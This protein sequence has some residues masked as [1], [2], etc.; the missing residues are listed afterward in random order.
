MRDDAQTADDGSPEPRPKVSSGGERDRQCVL[1]RTLAYT[2]ACLA[3]DPAAAEDLA[4]DVVLL[5]LKKLRADAGCFPDDAAL[6]AWAG[7][8]IRGRVLNWILSG[9]SRDAHNLAVAES[10][11]R[12]EGRRVDPAIRADGRDAL[13]RLE[14]AL[15]QMAERQRTAFLGTRDGG[16]SYRALASARRVSKETVRRQVGQ[17]F[18]DLRDALGDAL[19]FDDDPQWKVRG[20]GRRAA[21]LDEDPEDDS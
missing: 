19:D 1:V 15:R 11:A 16:M 21:F 5:L 14:R 7:I 8:T 10:H 12:H 2:A 17:A 4:Q 3:A 20:P 18:H 13:T 9:D 6:A